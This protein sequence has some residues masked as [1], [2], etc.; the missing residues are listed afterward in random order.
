MSE[1]TTVLPLA[2]PARA[3]QMFPALT[4]AQIAR[5]AQH[6][7]VRDV[8]RREIPFDVGQTVVPF[9]VIT[10]GRVE[11]V[12]PAAAARIDTV[13]TTHGPGEFTGEANMLSGRRA[14]VR[15]RVIEAGEVIE[16]DRE[17][18]LS[19]VQTD[20]ELSEIIMRAF[21]LRRVE[22][23]AH[24]LGDVVLVGSAH[25]AGTLRVKEFLTRNG[26][27][28]ASID[29]DRDEGLHQDRA[30]FVAR[31]PRGGQMAAL[32]HASSARNKSARGVRGR[33]RPWRKHQ[34]RRIGGGRGI[35][36]SGLRSSSLER[37]G[38]E[39]PHVRTRLR[40][41]PRDHD[42]E[43]PKRRECEECV[44]IHSRWMHLRTCQECG[45]TL[46]CDDS[47]NR[48]ASA[49]AGASGHPVIASAEPGE[50]WLYCYPDDGFAE[51]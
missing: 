18:L 29:L 2:R 40:A 28:F 46:C 12:R 23:I 13:V 11:I 49:H 25:C 22:L 36:C 48:H 37:V 6:G 31:R 14:L 1:T 41:H 30:G 38:G 27:L 33:G 20:D 4:G 9:F 8:A 42:V 51:Y 44:K 21:I 32:P 19:L 50:R 10:K 16:L 5:V 34:A 43:H 17:S 39:R 26:H 35:D 7:R 3:E 45:V 47:P 24:G 15:G